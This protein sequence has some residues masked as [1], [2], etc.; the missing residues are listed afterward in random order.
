[1]LCHSDIHAICVS[2]RIGGLE[3]LSTQ[4]AGLMGVSR[5]I[6]GLENIRIDYF[7]IVL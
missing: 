3:N 6:G 1:M 5:R 4:N 2:R 7:N